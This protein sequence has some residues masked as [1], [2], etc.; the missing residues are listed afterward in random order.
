MTGTDLAEME[1]ILTAK[2]WGCLGLADGEG[3]Y[4][5]PVL[6]VA[7]PSRSPSSA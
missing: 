3:I 7:W 6:P 2:S 5:L 1:A 4:V